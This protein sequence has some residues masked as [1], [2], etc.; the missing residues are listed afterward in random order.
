MSTIG[1]EN[2][3]NVTFDGDPVQQITIDGELVWE[4]FVPIQATG[5]R[6]YT[7]T[8]SGV[9]YR[10]HAFENVGNSE[11]TIQTHG[12]EQLIDVLVVG[13]GGSGCGGINGDFWGSGGGGGEV[14]FESNVDLSTDD[15]FSVSVGAGG[16]PVS[17]ST[18]FGNDGSNSQFGSIVAS[19][20]QGGQREMGGESGS[21]NSGG[22]AGTLEGRGGAGG[23]GDSEPG[24]E[25]D[26]GDGTYRGVVNE[27]MN[28]FSEIFGTEYGDVIDGNVWFGGG[29]A[30][31]DGDEQTF[32][33]GGN[34]GGG[35]GVRYTEQTEGDTNTGGGGSE[36]VQSGVGGR[37]GSG[38]VLV[39]Y[40]ITQP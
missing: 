22:S 23:G 9:T 16:E 29:G 20:G 8:D 10:V 11:F 28:G 27:N 34:G 12:T 30:G 38:I 35:A 19:G 18:E 7:I 36:R 33:N 31:Y 40:P 5:G 3:S 26:G 25:E 6:T 24:V 4:S 13:G 1:D 21:G 14:V 2:I 32:G 17:D 37:G 39:R 15:S